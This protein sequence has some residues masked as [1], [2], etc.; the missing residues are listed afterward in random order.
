MKKYPFYTIAIAGVFLLVIDLIAFSGIE[1]LTQNL[2]ERLQE[3]IFT[4]YWIISLSIVLGIFYTTLTFKAQY[5]QRYHMLALR[6]T[7]I[8]MISAITKAAFALIYGASE[9]SE[10]MATLSP[11]TN[12]GMLANHKEVVTNWVQ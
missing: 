5:N 8:S 6:I 2:S 9:V 12:L 4:F 1:L 3:F 10:M 11:A 7:G